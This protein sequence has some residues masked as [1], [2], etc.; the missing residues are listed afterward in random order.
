MTQGLVSNEF[1]SSK[2]TGNGYHFLGI[3]GFH[4]GKEWIWY[5]FAFLIPFTF[6]AGL[7]LG[8]VLK[9]VRIEPKVSSVKKKNKV[10][11]GNG[12]E[13]ATTSFNLPFTP[14]DLTFDKL[15]YEVKASTGDE[16][17]KLLNEV[18]GVFAAGRMVALMGSSGAGYVFSIAM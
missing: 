7:V 14:V 4:V 13:D 1:M 16:T 12:V 10:S 17:L 18:S 9:T 2:Y 11:I 8:I 15:V 5:T 3:R 6:F